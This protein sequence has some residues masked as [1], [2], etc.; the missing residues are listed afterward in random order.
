MSGTGNSTKSVSATGSQ[1]VD[2][3]LTTVA[4]G[5]ATINYAFSQSSA[6]YSYA[7]TGIADLPANFN[8]ISAAQETAIHF[9]LNADSGPAASRGFSVEGFT[10]LGVDSLGNAN[11]ATAEI[12][13]GETSSG[14]VGTARVGDF[15]GNY[16]SSAVDDNGDV[17]FGTAINY[18]APE[19]GNYSWHT[20]LHEIGH[21]LGLKH[22]QENSIWGPMPSQW[23]SMEYSV[24][25]YR[26]YV[27]DPLNGG[28]SNEPLG[29]AQTFMMADIAAL[30]HMY[31][32]DYSTNSGNTV[33]KWNPNSGDTL[34]NGQVGIDAGG[35]RIFATIWDGGGND[36]YDLTAYSDNLV[37]DLRPGGY[38]K[39]SDAQLANLGDGNFSRGNVFNAM[40][41]QGDKRSLI[42]NAKGGTGSDVVVG[43]GAKN[44]LR[45]NDGEDTLRGQN[46]ND[47]LFGGSDND[48]LF[49]GKGKDKLD[50]G[51]GNDKLKGNG[52]NDKFVF[53]SNYGEDRILDFKNNKDIIQ[54]DDGLWTGSKSVKKVLNQFGTQNG[55]D[56][57]LDFGNGDIL[58]IKNATKSQ[59]QNDIDII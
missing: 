25:T 12:R 14:S 22:G 5:D 35:N 50:G 27:G 34:V 56:F 49:G 52:G 10:K 42:E 55:S 57:V 36:T 2:G 9:A 44:I 4:W 47:K 45:G 20:H 30:Q 1:F 39:F 41:Y 6:A 43:N 58:T 7:G 8:T 33:Y 37:I 26:S 31:G 3:V 29:F 53:K 38:S 24:M 59:L 17:W 40:L 54:L 19:A 15:P 23:D 28:Y 48:K 21:A 11:S 13:F 46:S 18:R 16:I 51:E 32:A